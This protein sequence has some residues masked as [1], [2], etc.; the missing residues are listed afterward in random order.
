MAVNIRSVDNRLQR[1]VAASATV[2]YA[3]SLLWHISARTGHSPGM[4]WYAVLLFL[5]AIL[6]W[7][8][9]ML[10][11]RRFADEFRSSSLG[12]WINVFKGAPAWLIGLAGLS[13]VYAIG[14][15]HS[16]Y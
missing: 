1:F 7:F 16:F 8:P 6:V 9:T 15:L 12:G 14:Q 2:G 3:L 4:P 11:L 10:S 13:F 5:G